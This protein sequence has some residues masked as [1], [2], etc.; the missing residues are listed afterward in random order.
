MEG[1]RLS[2]AHIRRDGASVFRHG[3]FLAVRLGPLAW[4]ESV[5]LSSLDGKNFATFCFRP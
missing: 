2:S 1:V 3:C 4:S 5:A